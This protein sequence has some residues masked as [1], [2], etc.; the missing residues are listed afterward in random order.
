[1]ER[2]TQET[3]EKIIMAQ[4]PTNL[5]QDSK[6][7]VEIIAAKS[8]IRSGL[9]YNYPLMV[10]RG[11]RMLIK[12]RM[13]QFK[14]FV[15]RLQSLDTQSVRLLAERKAKFIRQI[16]EKKNEEHTTTTPMS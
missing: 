5:N 10:K 7:L 14:R 9:A 15:K 12:I 1:M 6:D 16:E 8:L 11:R 4:E 3:R 13:R 2:Y